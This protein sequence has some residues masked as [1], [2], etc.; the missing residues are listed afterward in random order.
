MLSDEVKKYLD[1]LEQEPKALASYHGEHYIAK[2]I[3]EMLKADEK[4]EP[5]KEDIAEQ[6]AFDFMAEYSNDSSGWGTY[7]GPMFILP[8]DKGQM[9]EYPSVRRVDQETLEY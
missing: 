2:E 3:K 6:M 5:T 8:N 7:H 9:V 4:Y 1:N